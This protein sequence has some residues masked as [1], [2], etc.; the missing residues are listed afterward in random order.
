MSR[1]EPRDSASRP[2]P[3]TFPRCA[4]QITVF[5]LWTPVRDSSNIALLRFYTDILCP[6]AEQM[7]F[8]QAL[9]VAHQGFVD[10]R[11]RSSLK[12]ESGRSS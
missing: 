7:H 9:Q 6:G 2:E 12:G 3:E 1:F 10:F 5:L 11:L 8:G 4:L